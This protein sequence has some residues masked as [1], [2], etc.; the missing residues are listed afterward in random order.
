MFDVTRTR[1]KNK[2]TI[3]SP[4]ILKKMT[5]HWIIHT[6]DGKNFANTSP[7]KLWGMNSKNPCVQRMIK[8]IQEG[9]QLWFLVTDKFKN[10]KKQIVAT[11]TYIRHAERSVGPLIE[12]DTDT[13]RGWTGGV[14]TLT[15][16]TWD[17]DLFYKDLYDL[18]DC[19]GFLVQDVSQIIPRLYSE[20]KK[21]PNLPNDLISIRRFLKPV[22]KVAPL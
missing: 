3:Y 20:D 9:D 21:D 15:E 1:K 7:K 17:I 22:D 12:I 11:A 4:L 19:D 6:K 5:Q 18:R 2:F 16:I 10:I 13:D 14:S 8:K